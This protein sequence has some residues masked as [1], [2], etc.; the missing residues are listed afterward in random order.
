MTDADRA[1]LRKLAAR[2]GKPMQ[3]I[4]HDALEEYRRKHLL[5]Q[6]NAAFAALRKNPKAW[7]EE[8]KERGAWDA[9]LGDD[10]KGD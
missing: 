1:L 10:L 2:E 3:A 5:E 6:A 8:R 9:T 4:L 7:K